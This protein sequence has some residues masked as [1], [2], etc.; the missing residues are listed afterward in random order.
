MEKNGQKTE[1]E[2]SEY[3]KLQLHDPSSYWSSKAIHAI[4]TPRLCLPMILGLPFL[5]HNNIVVDAS[6]RT[7]IDKKC[8]FNLL[9]PRPPPMR[10]VK[11]K[12][13]EFFKELQQD[14]KLM[15]AELNMVCNDRLQHPSYKFEKFKPVEPVASIRQHIEVLAVQKELENLGTQMKSEFKDV[16]LEIPHLDELPTNVYC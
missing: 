12:L 11:K 14:R 1:F 15:V 16:F 5:S 13:K 8:D 6:T 4:V 3:V 9:H 10:L 2:F 7:A